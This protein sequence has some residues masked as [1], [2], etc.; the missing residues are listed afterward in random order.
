MSDPGLQQGAQDAAT[1]PVELTENDL[2]CYSQELGRLGGIFGGSASAPFNIAAVTI[3]SSFMLIAGILIFAQDS[4]EFSRMQMV[5]LIIPIITGVVGY[6][7]GK[8]TK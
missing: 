7:F 6:I 2:K 1:Q 3:S 5:S 4:P 8:G